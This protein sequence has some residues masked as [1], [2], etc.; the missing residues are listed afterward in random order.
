MKRV[1]RI[2][3][4]ALTALAL[5]CC[6][7]RGDNE[8]SVLSAY[9]RAE[10]G[11]DSASTDFKVGPGAAA[12]Q[13]TT[14]ALEPEQVTRLSL[15]KHEMPQLDDATVSDLQAKSSAQVRLENRFSVALQLV[16]EG[17]ARTAKT[18]P[19]QNGVIRVSRIGFNRDHTQALF[20]VEHVGCPL[21]GGSKYVLMKRSWLRSWNIQTQHY[22]FIS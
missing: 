10:L 20:E 12:L 17:A 2:A 21:C 16:P 7:E 6:N 15:L 5:L 13:D 18:L 9:F 22:S 19:E 11:N 4:F 8:Y 14:L 3:A 1:A